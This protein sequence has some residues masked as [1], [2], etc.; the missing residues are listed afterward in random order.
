[1]VC[2]SGEFVLSSLSEDTLRQHVFEHEFE[3]FGGK[4]SAIQHALA[5]SSSNEGKEAAGAL[6]LMEIDR[7]AST[8]CV[9]DALSI[10]DSCVERL[11]GSPCV[12]EWG[13][14]AISD[15][16]RNALIHLSTSAEMSGFESDQRDVE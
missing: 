12:R 8:P 5:L 15:H 4:V 16:F 7:A 14:Q 1:M 2:C 9:T 11:F 6:A 10:C 13:W 3:I